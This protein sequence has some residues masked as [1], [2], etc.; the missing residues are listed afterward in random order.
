V[1]KINLAPPV[2][3]PRRGRPS[4]VALGAA[5]VAVLGGVGWWYAALTRGEAHQ[6]EQV[7]ILN[8][9]LTIL[10]AMLGRGEGAREAMND[11]TRRTQAIHELTRGQGI[12]LRILD[13]V[14]DVVPP[15]LSLASLEARGLELRAA[16]SARSARAVADF[17]ANLRASGKFKDVEIVMSKQDLGKTPPG[18]VSFEVTCRFGP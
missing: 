12:A 6:A 3:R 8:R 17:T 5:S 1:I 4:P 18:P 10:Q 9:E 15:D 7:A 16:G 11:L 2:E 13:A 14:V